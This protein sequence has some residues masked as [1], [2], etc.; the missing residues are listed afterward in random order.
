M[1]GRSPHGAGLVFVFALA[2]Q[3]ALVRCAPA[4]GTVGAMLAQDSDGRLTVREAPPG[5]AAD[6][7]GLAAGDELLL[8]D[9][10]DVRAL[11]DKAIHR[12]L[13]GEIGTEVKLTVLRG[14]EVLHLTLKR[15]PAKK[16]PRAAPGAP[17]PAAD[18]A[19][20]APRAPAR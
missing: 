9:G 11:D 8:I 1:N 15:T 16:R 10:V 17:A 2:L 12:A 3:L 20:P 13:S 7:A 19:A 5:L 6:K 14:E 4:Q 18:S